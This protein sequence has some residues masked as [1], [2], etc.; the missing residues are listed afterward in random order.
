MDFEGNR[1]IPD[2]EEQTP[3]F[4]DIMEEVLAAVNPEEYFGEDTYIDHVSYIIKVFKNDK[5]STMFYLSDK[6]L[7]ERALLQPSSVKNGK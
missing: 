2:L 1:K 6:N 5:Y 3:I 7:K 4:S